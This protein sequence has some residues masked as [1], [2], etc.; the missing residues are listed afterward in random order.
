M[1]Q[2]SRTSL[3][4]GSSSFQFFSPMRK[5]LGMMKLP[6]MISKMNKMTN[7]M[8]IKLRFF[9]IRNNLTRMTQ[10]SMKPTIANDLKKNRAL[11]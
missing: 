2:G 10:A 9:P 5:K 6:Q 7:M 3:G 8:F 1:P 11:I 4:F